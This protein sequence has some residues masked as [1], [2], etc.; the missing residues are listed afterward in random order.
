MAVE[1]ETARATK[2]GHTAVCAA[3]GPARCSVDATRGAPVRSWLTDGSPDITLHA[4]SHAIRTKSSR[5]ATLDDRVGSFAA[6]SE[7]F[8]F[9][10]GCT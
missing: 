6:R 1:D 9:W 8:C 3:S 2:R 10:F 7:R 4:S 5:V